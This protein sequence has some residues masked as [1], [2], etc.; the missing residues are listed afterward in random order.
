MDHRV[1][2]QVLAAV[3]A[4]PDASLLGCRSEPIIGSSGAAT[5]AVTRLSGTARCG[6]EELPFRLVRKEF[7]PV[8]TGAARRARR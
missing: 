1:P 8:S 6:T 2:D 3:L 4:R 5:G 7:H